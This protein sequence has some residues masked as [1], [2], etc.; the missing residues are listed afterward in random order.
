MAQHE[1]I[2]TIRMEDLLA[3]STFKDKLRFTPEAGSSPPKGKQGR[4]GGG[5][6]VGDGAP[7][8]DISSALYES[9]QRS[10]WCH[11]AAAAAAAAANG[12]ADAP[13]LGGL[14]QALYVAALR[15]VLLPWQQTP[16]AVSGSFPERLA[17]AALLSR[18]LGI[19]QDQH[20]IALLRALEANNRLTEELALQIADIEAGRLPGV[21][22][23][24]SSLSSESFA[25]WKRSAA[26]DAQ[27]LL[28]RQVRFPQFNALVELTLEGARGLSPLPKS[29][30]F[31]AAPPLHAYA[32]VVL[33]EPVG[34]SGK[35]KEV[36][37]SRHATKTAPQN[38]VNPEWSAALPPML[39]TAEGCTL[40]VKVSSKSHE[41]GGGQAAGA[42]GGA[43]KGGDKSS[44]GATGGKL[45][46]SIG[47]RMNKGLQTGVPLLV[48]LD[49][50]RKAGDRGPGGCGCFGGGGADPGG[51]GGDA[52][53][54][55]GAG[56]EDEDAI[57]GAVTGK[58][59]YDP[60][61]DEIEG[62]GG[63]VACG[64]LQL[65]VQYLCERRPKDDAEAAAIGAAAAARGATYVQHLDAVLSQPLRVDPLKGGFETRHKKASVRLAPDAPA[66]DARAG[67]GGG[68]VGVG[69]LTPAAM[70]R[71]LAAVLHAA[72]LSGALSAANPFAAIDSKAPGGGAAALLAAAAGP[73]PD[74]FSAAALSPKDH[75]ALLVSYAREVS[76]PAASVDPVFVAALQA[77]GTPKSLHEM[78]FQEPARR[79]LPL[80]WGLPLLLRFGRLY[81]VREEAQR[82]V[83]LQY[84]LLE[85]GQITDD[86]LS[87]FRVGWEASLNGH[88]GALTSDEME[89]LASVMGLFLH[90]AVPALNTHYTSFPSAVGVN[91]FLQLL[92]MVGWAYTWDP[93]SETPVALLQ[94]TLTRAAGSRLLRNLRM[95][96]ATLQESVIKVT[97]EVDAASEDLSKDV[98]IQ[99]TLPGLSNYAL[100][101]SRRR[102]GMMS[103]HFAAIFAYG[104]GSTQALVPLLLRLESSVNR[105]H[106]L[107]FKHGLANKPNKPT[108]GVATGSRGAASYASVA[109]GGQGTLVE[110]FDI[111]GAMIASLEQWVRTGSADLATRATR[112]M[113]NETWEQVGAV[114]SSGKGYGRSAVELQRM[115]HASLDKWLEVTASGSARRRA[116]LGAVIVACVA[117]LL[118]THARAFEA[119]FSELMEANAFPLDACPEGGSFLTGEAGGGGSGTQA[120]HARGG[121]ASSV[122]A[123]AT[124]PAASGP[125]SYARAPPPAARTRPG[126]NASMVGLPGHH[127]TPSSGIRS[128]VV[129]NHGRGPGAVLPD[130]DALA[131]ALQAATPGVLLSDELCCCRATLERL[132]S[133]TR[134]L[135]HTMAESLGDGTTPGGGS[136]GGALPEGAPAY[137]TT[138][139]RALEAEQSRTLRILDA[140]YCLEYRN[141]LLRMLM[142]AF[143]RQSQQQAGRRPEGQNASVKVLE[144]ILTA[145]HDELMCML[146]NVPLVK[147]GRETECPD[148]LA[149]LSG[150]SW[151]G[152]MSALQ[153]LALGL[154]GFRPLTGDEAEWARE[155][156][157]SLQGMYSDELQ[158]HAPHVVPGGSLLTVQGEEEN[159]LRARS[160]SHA[161]ASALLQALTADSEDLQDIYGAQFSC[162]QF[163][164]LTQLGGG[165]VFVELG[166]Q[167]VSLLD[168]LRLLR[169]R[170]KVE[171][172]TQAFIIESLKTASA[173][174]TQVIFGL[175]SSERVLA[176]F[177]CFLATGADAAAATATSVPLGLHGDT[178]AHANGAPGAPTPPTGVGAR[179]DG[180]IGGAP[181]PAANASLAAAGGVGRTSAPM[182]A[183]AAT[184]AAQPAGGGVAD[185]IEA[186]GRLYL[187]Q[188]CLAYTTILDG[189]L[190]TTSDT[191]VVLLRSSVA[192]KIGT[193]SFGAVRGSLL[194][195]VVFET[196]D[197]DS[198]CFSGFVPGD[199]DRLLTMLQQGTGLGQHYHGGGADGARDASGGDGAPRPPCMMSAPCH[200][201][202]MLLDT[203]GVLYVCSDHVEFVNAAGEVLH[204]IALS[205]VEAVS[206]QPLTMRVGESVMS[207]KVSTSDKPL[208]LGGIT[209]ALI[210]SLKLAIMS[211][212]SELE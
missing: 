78:L 75:A 158:A 41:A 99:A 161:Y 194:H 48:E 182:P 151:R 58:A 137:L 129:S 56:D 96:P 167:Q 186:T 16:Q 59:V 69:A 197:H 211:L 65:R 157:I 8:D 14:P 135:G 105:H 79:F 212:C 101:N 204:W 73:P 206:Q 209:D 13:L 49:L 26:R 150:A 183:A 6:G 89:G 159:S 170:R 102:Y 109:S 127:R 104:P 70:F 100:Q 88:R 196:L 28:Q 95:T 7:L 119:P 187:T 156:L 160:T 11:E 92:E 72:H 63:R 15:T 163:A 24:D 146:K 184:N 111:E 3:G 27:A 37:G 106:R 30:F 199:R 93:E 142:S 19:P 68:V 133:D 205:N 43:E 2:K 155:F 86:L 1:D 189:D 140:A 139:W 4:P 46:G 131:S 77:S 20:K 17:R 174:V 66:A 82:L 122:Q 115:L 126:S 188:S 39:F 208:L 181:A 147:R 190:R 118:A 145:M 81:R 112:L 191:T 44:H 198:Y 60:E 5:P 153:L 168:L 202:G 123:G 10:P 97:D 32:A 103:G 52:G 180:G 54:A 21:S 90:K 128:M 162:L 195:H 18:S 173:I 74:A 67:T 98:S 121:S 143:G 114:G 91:A 34:S 171:P 31:G 83:L 36:P 22:S 94:E 53:G 9:Y 62:T 45:L 87:A 203:Q 169:Q 175:H 210:A 80:G 130:A 25:A 61:R 134:A 164:P 57:G 144:G 141:T 12:A 125:S 50:Y 166:A 117:Q 138:A 148:A 179:A 132:I 55:G 35:Q 201:Y 124:P 85:G 120:H 110:L 76:Q 84:M 107:L 71:R 64:T 185:E 149:A 113:A 108:A 152:T 40:S 42:G 38:V 165:E 33:T 23:D 154:A 207:I 136:G 47:L 192:P 172:N 178:V 51:G 193:A 29:G 200:V 176:E 177:K 116:A